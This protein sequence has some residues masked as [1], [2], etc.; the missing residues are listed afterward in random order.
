MS[1]RR[2]TG[3]RR[4]WSGQGVADYSPAFLSADD[5]Q[6]I[7]T[8]LN[9][10][11]IHKVPGSFFLALREAIG[12]YWSH[13]AIASSSRPAAVRGELNKT[14]QAA[15]KLDALLENLDAN[16]AAL[17]RAAGTQAIELQAGLAPILRALSNACSAAHEYPK[18]GRLPEA[19]R[20]WL[21]VDVAKAFVNHLDTQP[22]ATRD[23]P[24]E[25]VLTRVLKITID[26]YPSSGERETNVHD[27]AQRAIKSISSRRIR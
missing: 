8:T 25:D 20:L 21:A 23:G 5:R 4:P 16:S 9:A 13:R 19:D 24:Y 10:M 11:G 6:W 7:E 27:L 15:E 26:N 3:A 22:T 14:L 17:L 18:A 2:G 1:G 12:M